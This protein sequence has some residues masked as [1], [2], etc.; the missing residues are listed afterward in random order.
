V[1]R[2]TAVLLW[3]VPSV[4]N[5]VDWTSYELTPQVRVFAGVLSQGETPAVRACCFA[6][7]PRGARPFAESRRRL[8]YLAELGVDV[9]LILRMGSEGTEGASLPNGVTHARG[10]GARAN[11]AELRGLTSIRRTLKAVRSS[12]QMLPTEVRQMTTFCIN[13]VRDGVG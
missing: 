7:R 9:N 11:E 4:I 2:A 1:A 6:I 8:L 10:E 3:T 12:E 5:S 13:Q